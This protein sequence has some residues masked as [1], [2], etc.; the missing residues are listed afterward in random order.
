MGMF[1]YLICEAPL[2]ETPEPPPAG[3]F[4]TKDT[5]DQSLRDYVI[6]ADGSLIAKPSPGVFS[7][8]YVRPVDSV[9]DD[10]H[11]D[12]VFYTGRDPN[13]GPW[14]E[15]KARFTDGRLSRITLVDFKP[16]PE[17]AP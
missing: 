2:P 13:R 6:T 4:Q 7:S 10:A 8:P 1:D 15:Y 11:G 17:N 12:I 14:W 9:F 16:S 3:P 5:P